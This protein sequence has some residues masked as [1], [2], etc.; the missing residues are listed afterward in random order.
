MTVADKIAA[1]NGAA[2]AVGVSPA[3]SPALGASGYNFAAD[4]LK[5]NLDAGRAGKPAYIDGRGTWTYG[6][7]ADR[8]NRFGAALRGLGVRREERV[9]MAVLDTIDWPTAFLG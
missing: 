1:A 6:Q 9:L 8:V 4:V 2:G 7:L 3:E 5:R